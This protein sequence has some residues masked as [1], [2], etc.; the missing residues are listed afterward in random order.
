M[1]K[2]KCK[3]DWEINTDYSAIKGEERSS[4]LKCKVYMT[5]NEVAKMELWK[6]TT[7]IQK[8]LSIGAILIAFT[9]LIIS[10]LK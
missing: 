5:A 8:W 1:S 10:F 2:F 3:H 9:S 6:H 7:G 4:V